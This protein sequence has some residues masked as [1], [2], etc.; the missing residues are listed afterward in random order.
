MREVYCPKCGA[1]EPSE[2]PDGEGSETFECGSCGA[3][4]RLSTP[5]TA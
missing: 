4:W 1:S 3:V 5:E 2:H